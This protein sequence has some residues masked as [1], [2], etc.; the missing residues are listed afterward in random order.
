MYFMR[1]RLLNIKIDSLSGFHFFFFLF[2]FR[3][4]ISISRETRK[5][6]KMKELPLTLRLVGDLNFSQSGFVYRFQSPLG[7]LLSSFRCKLKIW[8]KKEKFHQPLKHISPHKKEIIINL[9]I[10]LHV[11]RWKGFFV[12]C[13]LLPFFFHH[14]HQM[15]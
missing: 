13:C 1:L 7:F 10:Y 11:G 12:C 2:F 3:P 6:I 5:D 15:P 14:H 9:D 8:K 4:L